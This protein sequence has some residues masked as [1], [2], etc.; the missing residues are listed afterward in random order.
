MDQVIQGDKTTVD[1]T[2]LNSGDE[3]A[4]DVQ[5]SLLLPEGINSEPIFLGRMDPDKSQTETFDIGIDSTVMP[6]KYSMVILTEYKDANGYPFSSVSPKP[7]IIKRFRSGQIFG[8]ISEL[9]L[10]DKET[11]KLTLELRNMDQK[12]HDIQIKLFG[13][14]E[15]KI[16]SEEKSLMLNARGEAKMDYDISSFGAL[17]GSSYVVFATLDYEEGGIHYSSTAS[18]IVK[19]VDQTE[20]AGDQTKSAALPGW[21]PLAALMVL[22]LIFVI[23]QFRK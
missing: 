23:Y 8:K 10:G 12:D 22:V 2:L 14:K 4:Y 9:A 5:L 13:P 20:S 11:R 18:G 17:P 1:V 7:L 21:L 19:V 15:L 3:P 16:D 6:G